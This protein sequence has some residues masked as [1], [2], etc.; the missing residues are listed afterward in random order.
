MIQNYANNGEDAFVLIVDSS[1]KDALRDCLKTGAK[2]AR[3]ITLETGIPKK[4]LIELS[5]DGMLRMDQN[6]FALI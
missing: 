5:E 3:K 6:S 2:T 4:R 1:E